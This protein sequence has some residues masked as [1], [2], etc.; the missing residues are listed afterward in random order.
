M[1]PRK[2]LSLSK[3]LSLDTLVKIKMKR[4]PQEQQKKRDLDQRNRLKRIKAA[5]SWLSQR[6]PECFKASNPKPLKLHIEQDILADI[7]NI[8][9]QTT[10][11]S[12]NAIHDALKY[13]VNSLN[14]L[15]SHFKYTHRIDLDGQPSSLFPISLQ[16]KKYAQIRLDQLHIRKNETNDC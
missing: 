7:A 5:L 10:T 6:Y 2:V 11:P 3:P 8:H 12:K 9:D 1:E 15:E 14:Y 13:Y 16:Q 4:S